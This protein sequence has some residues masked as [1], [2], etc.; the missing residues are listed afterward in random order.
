[1]LKEKAYLH[2]RKAGSND[3]SLVLEMLR[4]SASEQGVQDEFFTTEADLLRDIFGEVPRAN[5]LIIEC[6][7]GVVGLTIFFFNFASFIG[8]SGVYI[9][10]IFVR[11]SFQNKSFGKQILA[12]M[13]AY[14]LENN[15]G[16]LEWLVLDENKKARNFYEKM[17]AYAENGWTVH[18]AKG[19]TLNT[20]AAFYN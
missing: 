20:M 4:E 8:C 11:P 15:C 14:A 17:G 5:I 1:M 19:K 2:F 12:Y 7:A 3:A 18:R 16:L 6:E 13:A 10:D 9:E